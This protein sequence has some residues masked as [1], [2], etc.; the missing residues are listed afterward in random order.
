LHET[1]FYTSHEALLLPYEE[2]LTR[3]DS[4][5]GDWYDTSGHFVWIGARTGQL[6]GAQIEFARGIKNP[7]GLKVGP[8]LDEG[9][10]LRIIDRLNPDN[11]PGRLTLIA[12]MGAD[13]VSKLLPPLLK[14]VKQSGAAVLW[15]CDAVHGNTVTSES[16]FKTRRFDDVLGEIAGF[17]DACRTE[18]V[19]PGGIHIELTGQQVTE[20]T[21][22]Q[23]NLTD[24]DLATCYQTHCDPRLNANQALELAF[25][26]AEKL[27]S[28]R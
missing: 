10:L 3:V 28:G 20:C 14:A 12:R 11:I 4:T 2:A 26:V 1:D 6:D 7:I 17:F 19:H 21:G 25:L 23:L 16:G 9:T 13:K 27:K 15:S 22:G 24:A 18:G 8:D 5:T